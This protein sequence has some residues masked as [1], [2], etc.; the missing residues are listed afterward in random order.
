[1]TVLAPLDDPLEPAIQEHVAHFLA[2]QTI[3]TYAKAGAHQPARYAKRNGR[4]K[5]PACVLHSPKIAN[6]VIP[7]LITK[8]ETVAAPVPPNGFAQQ[9]TP[10][11]AM[12]NYLPTR[13]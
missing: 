13:A 10:E 4:P 8:A 2:A 7:A 9:S 5:I 1:M 3:A 11:Q 12:P 6:A